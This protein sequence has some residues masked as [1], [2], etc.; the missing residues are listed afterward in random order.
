MYTEFNTITTSLSPFMNKITDAILSFNTKLDEIP[1]QCN[2]IFYKQHE[3]LGNTN[4][5]SPRLSENTKEL[6]EE[7]IIF[8]R[9]HWK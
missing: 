2:E 9:T 6:K 5:I 7:T 4:T 3:E 1:E 8:I